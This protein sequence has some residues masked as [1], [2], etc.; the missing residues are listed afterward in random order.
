M[1]AGE[2]TRPLPSNLAAA[3]LPAEPR[4]STP[5]PALGA[6]NRFD[7]AFFNEPRPTLREFLALRPSQPASAEQKES[8]QA[9]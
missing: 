4:L 8:R 3:R 2:R 5:R 9:A 7:H 6:S 1:G